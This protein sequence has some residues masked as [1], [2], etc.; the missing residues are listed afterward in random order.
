ME[1]KI[2]DNNETIKRYEDELKEMNLIRDNNRN[3]DQI[4]NKNI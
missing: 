2:K 4:R 1:D 3:L